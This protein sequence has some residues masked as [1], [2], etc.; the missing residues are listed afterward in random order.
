MIFSSFVSAVPLWGW[1][2]MGALAQ[3]AASTATP[4]TLTSDTLRFHLDRVIVTA[5]RSPQRLA[6]APAATSLMERTELT[7]PTVNRVVDALEQIPG[8]TFLDFHGTGDDPQPVIRGFYGGGESEYLLLLLDGVPVTRLHDGR[9]NW[10][11]VPLAAVDRVEVVRGGASPVWGDG[12]LG[13]VVNLVTRRSGASPSYRRVEAQA[14]G[15]GLLAG[16]AYAA[17]AVGPRTASAWGGFQRSDGFRDHSQREGG[18][19]GASVDLIPAQAGKS[20]TLSTLHHWRDT[21]N[22]GPITQATLDQ[23]ASPRATLPVFRFDEVLES[24]HRLGVDGTF[25]PGNGGARSVKVSGHLVGELSRLTEV[26][27][28]PLSPFFADSQE[29]SASSRRLFGSGKAEVPLEMG[30]V[31]GRITVGF[32]LALGRMENEYRAVLSGGPDTYQSAPV[33]LEAGPLLAQG[34][35]MRGSAALF[36][37]TEV[38]PRPRLHLHAGLRRDDL[39]DRYTPQGVATSNPDGE[40]ATALSSRKSAWSPSVGLNLL[41]AG[42]GNGIGGSSGETRLFASLGRSFRAATLDQLFDQRATPVPFPP[43]AITTS[44]PLL[45]P[46]RGIQGEV[47]LRYGRSWEEAGIATDASVAAFRMELQ[48]QLDFDLAQFKYVNLGRSRQQGLELSGA[49]R[50]TSG[51]RI[52]LGYTLQHAQERG[53]QNPGTQ[54][55]AVPRHTFTAG[56]SV[57]FG[58]ASGDS[59]PEGGSRP[60]VSVSVTRLGG[61]WL[62]DA[63]H[64]P[65]ESFTRVDAGVSLPLG[66]F[67]LQLEV[68][69]ALNRSYAST[70]YPDPSGTATVYLHPA[71]GRTFQLGMATSAPSLPGTR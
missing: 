67:E 42:A 19:L 26:R 64:L 2:L 59:P 46:Q 13:G 10:D 38:N 54:L 43:Y 6:E 45:R 24:R 56:G 47:G 12:A 23:G 69:N 14:G 68:R 22:P 36:L 18:S 5:T 35:G 29:R 58:A 57:A 40:G 55:K 51:T 11:L 48:D 21:E 31:L 37:L 63:N 30:G 7:Q 65:L 20:L 70:G 62:D 9:I 33:A 8:L 3:S 17:G 4:D 34:V 44:N 1:G 16:S 27:T 50:H 52:R 25:T 41:L 53:G 61:I 71:A 39:R 66:R 28:L 15:L 32:D 60:M 49:L